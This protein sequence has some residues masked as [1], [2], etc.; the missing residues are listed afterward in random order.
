MIFSLVRN[1]KPV[2]SVKQEELEEPGVLKN[3]C[4]AQTSEFIRLT[5]LKE[6][7]EFIRLTERKET[8][9]RER[10]ERN[11]SGLKRNI[12]SQL[13]LSFLSCLLL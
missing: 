12:G 2:E 3:I 4:R 13:H 10:K 11:P 9:Q 8:Q 7:S 6:T 1:Q 5:E